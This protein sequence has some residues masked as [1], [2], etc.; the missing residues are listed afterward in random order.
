MVLPS[1]LLTYL[2]Q[3][4]CCSASPSASRTR[5][6]GWRPS[7]RSCRSWCWR[8]WPR[9][10]LS[11]A[12]LRGVLADQPGH[13]ARLLAPLNVSTPRPASRG[14]IYIP[15]VNW[16]LA[17]PVHGAGAGLP[18]VGE[19]GRGLRHGGE[20]HDGADRAGVLRRGA[21]PLRLV[22]VGG[23]AALLFL[24]VDLAFFGATAFKIPTAAGCRWCSAAVVFY[25][26]TT[27]RTSGAWCTSA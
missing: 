11:G 21:P 19:P 9:H 18:Q 15:T 8:R 24:L 22:A 25:V 3:G 14:Q 27:W 5:S 6:S 12:D 2:G 16:A 4:R 13:P 26:L 17:R 10:R 20:H 7:G 1:L 23:P